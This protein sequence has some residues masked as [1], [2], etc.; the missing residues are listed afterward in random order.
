[1]MDE[2]N[3]EEMRREK[4]R[5]QV[6]F[7]NQPFLILGMVINYVVLTWPC[8]GATTTDQTESRKG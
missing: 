4:R 3:R 1:M 7:F 6:S 8:L 5:I 2:Q